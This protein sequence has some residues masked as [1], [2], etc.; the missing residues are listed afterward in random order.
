MNYLGKISSNNDESSDKTLNLLDSFLN[1]KKQSEQ[2]CYEMIANALKNYTKSQNDEFRFE[3]KI[4][5]LSEGLV[6]SEAYHGSKK[7]RI[8]DSLIVISDAKKD[9]ASS[10]GSRPHRLKKLKIERSLVSEFTNTARVKSSRAN[11]RK[12]GF[13]STPRSQRKNDKRIFIKQLEPLKSKNQ[14]MMENVYAR[15]NTRSNNKSSSIYKAKYESKLFSKSVLIIQ[16][17][18]RRLIAKEKIKNLNNNDRHEKKIKLMK[19]LKEFEELKAKPVEEWA[20]QDSDLYIPANNKL[21]YF[22]RVKLDTIP[23]DNHEKFS[24]S[25]DKL[26]L[27]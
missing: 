19:A 8:P 9:R 16:C 6:I 5:K 22:Q 25:H 23:E 3:E 13:Q 10:G 15:Q 20:Y 4:S 18:F 11:P 21:H 1:A 2:L 26:K 7:T 17:V 12:A 27:S 24:L 14:H